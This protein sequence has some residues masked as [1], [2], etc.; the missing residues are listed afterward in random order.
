MALSVS[1][2]RLGRGVSDLCD[3]DDLIVIIGGLMCNVCG[4]GALSCVIMR[5]DGQLITTIF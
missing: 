3:C 2:Y 5:L 1:Q 4:S